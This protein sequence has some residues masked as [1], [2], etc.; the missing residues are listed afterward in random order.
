MC[1]DVLWLNLEPKLATSAPTH[2]SHQLDGELS[3]P[4]NLTESF[5]HEMAPLKWAQD[6]RWSAAR[7][8]KLDHFQVMQLT[9]KGEGRS[10]SSPVCFLCFCTQD[11][12]SEQ[13]LKTSPRQQAIDPEVYYTLIILYKNCAY[14]YIIVNNKKLNHR[15]T[16]FAVQSNGPQPQ[17][18]ACRRKGSCGFPSLNSDG[19]T[20][21]SST[22]WLLRMAAVMPLY[23]C[24]CRCSVLAAV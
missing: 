6:H 11:W 20:T 9:H 23:A 24:T 10:Q 2:M 22:S 8:Q 5:W 15:G 3:S 16:R 19:D 7:F 13:P 21:N 14:H 1:S 17:V 4:T 18:T 12:H